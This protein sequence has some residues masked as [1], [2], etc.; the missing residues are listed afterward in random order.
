MLAGLALRLLS[1]GLFYIRAMCRRLLWMVSLRGKMADFT[2]RGMG[3]ELVTRP[4]N[5]L[6]VKCNG[7]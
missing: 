6:E 5:R 4:L 2:T 7:D 3:G 1:K